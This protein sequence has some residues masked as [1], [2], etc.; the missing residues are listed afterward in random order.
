MEGHGVVDLGSDAGFL[1]IFPQLVAARAAEGVLMKDMTSVGMNQRGDEVRDGGLREEPLIPRGIGAAGLGPL[2]QIFELDAEDDGLEGID[3]AVDADD[4]MVVTGLHAVDAEDAQFVGQGIVIGGH[5]AG[6]S[7]ATEIL[8][9]EEAEAIDES[10]GSGGTALEL[11]A[12]GLGGIL[13]DGDSMA[14]GDLEDGVHARALAEKVDRQ[15]GP[16]ARGDGGLELLDIEIEIVGANIDID[17]PG[18]EPGN[19][20]GRREEGKG[21][22]NDLIALA[23]AEGHEGQEQGIGAGGAADGVPDT[24]IGGRLLLES[25]DLRAHDELLTVEDAGD[26][27][28]H[29]L[30]YRPMLRD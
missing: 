21:D 16:G 9:G 25:L 1:Q 23:D 14:S 11:G 4:V 27:L 6:V 29:L 12:D 24:A 30:A 7:R 20:A 8:G 17:G 19:G 10:H 13:D 26:D 2:L 28:H 18:A 22:G 3:A 15:D 5:H